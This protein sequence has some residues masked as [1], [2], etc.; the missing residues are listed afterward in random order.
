MA[1]FA[2]VKLMLLLQADNTPASMKNSFCSIA[3]AIL[4]GHKLFISVLLSYLRVG[5][6]H[7]DVESRLAIIVCLLFSLAEWQTPSDIIT[8]H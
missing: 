2:V 3:A 6:A 1:H 8:W 5:H 7:E 4:A